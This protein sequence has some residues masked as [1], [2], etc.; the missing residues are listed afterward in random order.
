MVKKVRLPLHSK[1]KSRLKWIKL[2]KR[3]KVFGNRHFSVGAV[4]KKNGKYLLINRNLYPSGYAGI[5]GHV[6]KR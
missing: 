2:D 5:A 3:D 1:V 4:I 6:N